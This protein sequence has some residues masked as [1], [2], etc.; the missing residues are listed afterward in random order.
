[1]LFPHKT[2]LPFHQNQEPYI[3]LLGDRKKKQKLRRRM[4]KKLEEKNKQLGTYIRIHTIPCT[5]ITWLLV[6]FDR[7]FFVW[8][9]FAVTIVCCYYYQYP[10]LFM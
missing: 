10:H 4:F 6:C 8:A 9:S 2:S 5:H 1:M 3:S 7:N